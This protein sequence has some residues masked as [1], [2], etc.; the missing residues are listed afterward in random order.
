MQW[1]LQGTYG[2]K[3][4]THYLD[5]FLFIGEEGTQDCGEALQDF[6]RLADHLGVPLAPSKTEGPAQVLIF[7]GIELDTVVGV[8]RLPVGKVQALVQDIQAS[9][10]KDKATLGS[11]KSLLGNL[12]FAGRVIRSGRVFARRLA[13]ATAK[14]RKKHHL[15]RLSKGVKKD[16][17]MWAEFLANFNGSVIW[18]A[19]WAGSPSC[20]CSRIH[21]AGRAS[22]QSWGASGVRRNGQ[23]PG[24]RGKSR[25][26]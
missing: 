15:V 20:A 16:L 1:A 6:K 22:E 11:N 25:P 26:M 17:L 5:D 19:P 18:R 23:M 10:A 24:I 2:V 4:V 3:G 9:L 14:V 21:R 8:S 12:N 13:R 7:L